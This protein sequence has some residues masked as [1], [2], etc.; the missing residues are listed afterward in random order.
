MVNYG[1]ILLPLYI[2]PGPNGANW[3]KLYNAAKAYPSL[4]FQAVINVEN[5]PGGGCPNSET[6]YAVNKLH[7]YTN[8]QT[9]G[10]VHTASRYDCGPEGKWICP[11]TQDVSAVKANIT[12]WQNWSK[13]STSQD[14]H[15]DGIF[16]DEAPTVAANIS[17]M[18]ILTT[19]AKN[20]LTKGPKTTLFNAGNPVDAGYWAIA[21][22]INVFEGTEAAYYAADIG[23]LDGGGL[24][25]QQTT[26][27]IHSYTDPASNVYKDVN[28][29]IS[30]NNDAIAGLFISSIEP[31]DISDPY[32][33]FSPLWPTFTADMFNVT[34][35][36]AGG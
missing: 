13:C 23:A 15:M 20:T 19:F 24:Y 2:Y 35:A 25:S 14:L 18:K 22:Y 28:T 3:T 1:F 5:G 32:I 34:K 10:Y 11:A 26:L 21:D 36:N 30:L 16:F 27:L 4:N 17:Y 29:I 8:V 33:A 12:S 9:L 7:S 6:A 31:S